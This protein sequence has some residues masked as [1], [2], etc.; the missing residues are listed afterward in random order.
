MHA[1][2]QGVQPELQPHHPLQEAHGLQALHLL[3][4]WTGVPAQ[5]GPPQAQRDA[6]RRLPIDRGGHSHHPGLAE[7]RHSR[8]AGLVKGH[9]SRVTSLLEGRY[10]HV[11]SLG[12]GRHSRVTSL[13]KGRYSA[14]PGVSEEPPRSAVLPDLAQRYRSA[15]QGRFQGH[16]AIFSDSLAQGGKRVAC[17]AIPQGGNSDV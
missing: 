17:A 12:K 7:G 15:L 3:P 6:A 5:G 14:I 13:V 1:L 2:P 9:R 16:D 11:S 10:P 4:L 8:V